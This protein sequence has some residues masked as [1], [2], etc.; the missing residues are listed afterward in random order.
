VVS[1]VVE[2]PMLDVLAGQCEVLLN[3]WGEHRGQEI[4]KLPEY[5]LVVRN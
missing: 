4:G 2:S 5:L 3:H 1:D